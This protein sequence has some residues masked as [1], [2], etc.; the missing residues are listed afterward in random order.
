MQAKLTTVFPS[1]TD[2]TEDHGFELSH[3]HSI[4]HERSAFA[5]RANNGKYVLSIVD[6]SHTKHNFEL[7]QEMAIAFHLHL[8][9]NKIVGKQK[10]NVSAFV[11][12]PSMASNS[13]RQMIVQVHLK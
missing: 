4:N 10:A 1:S 6:G 9:K 8:I 7:Q 11:A 3:S 5:K 2:A 12:V 13:Y